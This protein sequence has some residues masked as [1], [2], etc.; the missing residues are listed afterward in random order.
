[1]RVITFVF[2]A[3][4]MTVVP[5]QEPA[6]PGIVR[7]SLLQVG[8]AGL[9]VTTSSGDSVQCGFDGHTYMEKD[10]QRIFAGALHVSDPVEVV[11]DRKAS[12]C[13][14]RTVRVIAPG[15]RILPIRRSP[16]EYIYPRGNL[17][18]SGV[19]R[20]LNSE[21]V[22]LRTREEPEK[23]VLLRED[24]RY[25]DSGSPTDLS[26]LGVN[27]RVFIRGGRN[28]DNQLEA[29]QIIWGDIGGPGPGHG[30]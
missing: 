20:R 6:R 14:A 7:G 24:T 11:A 3:I 10:G 16:L 8:S 21:V 26:R 17:T 18:F 4:T 9:V 12:S 2:S 27:T 25:L 19:V 22:V 13:Y 28:I 1:M 5:A 30:E 29:Y 23:L 15:T